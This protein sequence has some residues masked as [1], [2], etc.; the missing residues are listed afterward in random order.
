MPK[1]PRPHDFLSSQLVEHLVLGQCG[2]GRCG[3]SESRMQGGEVPLK[4][5]AICSSVHLESTFTIWWQSPTFHPPLPT[6]PVNLSF[7]VSCSLS[8]ATN[9]QKTYILK[10]EYWTRQKLRN[11]W[12][13]IYSR[14]DMLQRLLITSCHIDSRTSFVFPRPFFSLQIAFF[15]HLCPRFPV[16][17][18]CLKVATLIFCY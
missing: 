8:Q 9:G 18:F 10:S 5:N 1:A 6:V 16:I 17:S 4:V 12:K 2:L 3:S 7:T 14:V 11:K 15:L 13:Q